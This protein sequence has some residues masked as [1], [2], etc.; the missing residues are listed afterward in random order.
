MLNFEKPFLQI[1]MTAV[2]FIAAQSVK[3][4]DGEAATQKKQLNYGNRT[5]W[6]PGSTVLA[7]ADGQ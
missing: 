6:Q 5:V 1:W 3:S 7:A 4:A 2:S